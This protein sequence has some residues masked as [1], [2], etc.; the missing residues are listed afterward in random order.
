MT[1]LV[2]ISWVG[3]T[4]FLKATYTGIFRPAN[5]GFLNPSVWSMSLAANEERLQRSVWEKNLTATVLPTSSS[6]SS[7]DRMTTSSSSLT[8]NETEK[9]RIPPAWGQGGTN[10]KVSKPTCEKE[11][12][13]FVCLRNISCRK[14]QNANLS[15]V[16]V[17]ARHVVNVQRVGGS[18]KAAA[19]AA[20]MSSFVFFFI[21]PK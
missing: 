19:V 20:V 4:H 7:S 11:N 12:F 2:T 15:A 6:S 17:F 1:L 18:G 9:M 3:A 16:G 13:L 10:T 5:G 14:N 21:F 8:T